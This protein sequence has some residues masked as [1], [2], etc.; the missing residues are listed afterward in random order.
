[1]NSKE[2][3][4]AFEK[5]QY[6]KAQ[7]QVRGTSLSALSRDLGVSPTSMTLVGMGVHRSKRIENAIAE[8]LDTTA[9]TLWPER[10]KNI[11]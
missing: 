2:N 10:F 11:G 3:K 6:V 5:H 8:A 7:L 4:A 1:M 9:E